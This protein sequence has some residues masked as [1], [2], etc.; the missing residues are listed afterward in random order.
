MHTRTLRRLLEIGATGALIIVL[1]SFTSPERLPSVM[2]VTPFI[3]LFIILYLATM[4]FLEFAN[5]ES[6]HLITLRIM[7]PRVVA[8][9]VAGF[10]ILLLVLQSI[11]QLSSREAL[12]AGAIFVIAYFYATKFSTDPSAR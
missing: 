11:G 9:L 12:T 3:L 2:L 8:G 1:L 7:R 6:D 10:P 5:R 4:A